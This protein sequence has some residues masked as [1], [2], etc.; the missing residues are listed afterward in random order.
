VVAH[1]AHKAMTHTLLSALL[2]RLADFASP[3]FLPVP[4]FGGQGVKSIA[5]LDLWNEQINDLLAAE[6]GHEQHPIPFPAVFVELIGIQ[7]QEAIGYN[8]GDANIAIH[9]LYQTFA[10]SYILPDATPPLGVGGLPQGAN[11]T[12]PAFGGTG[13]GLL[14]YQFLD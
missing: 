6:N 7:W 5:W 10:E 8:E 1:H 13:T 2:T 4:P 9:V 14:P 12:L 3:N 11:D